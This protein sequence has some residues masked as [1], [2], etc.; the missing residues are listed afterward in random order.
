MMFKRPLALLAAVLFAVGCESS[1]STEQRPR[2]RSEGVISDMHLSMNTA[3]VHA[4][5]LQQS[6]NA[7]IRQHTLYPYHFVAHSAEL[8]DI[9]KHEVHV[10]ARHY[11]ANPGPV[12]LN[13]GGEDDGLYEARIKTVLDAMTMH[14]VAADGI[15]VQEGLP[16]GDGYP[17]EQVVLVVERMRESDQGGGDRSDSSNR[18]MQRNRT[19]NQNNTGTTANNNGGR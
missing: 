19:N 7:I 15:K 17:S 16:G 13:R 5:Q 18:D 9:G 8:N 3:N 2:T 11:M 1:Q 14:G 6:E 10:L 4:F 12:N